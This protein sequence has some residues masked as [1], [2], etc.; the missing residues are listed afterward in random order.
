[1]VQGPTLLPFLAKH[2]GLTDEEL[3]FII[4]TVWDRMQGK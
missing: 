4:N 1:M 2:Y 3:D